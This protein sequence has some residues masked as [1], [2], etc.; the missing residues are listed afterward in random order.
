MASATSCTLRL[1]APFLF[2]LT[3]SVACKRVPGTQGANSG[4]LT[5]SWFGDTGETSIEWAPDGSLLSITT[6][7][8]SGVDYQL[9]KQEMACAVWPAEKLAAAFS[10][11]P[12]AVTAGWTGEALEALK[13]ALAGLPDSYLNALAE[14][15]RKNGFAIKA[16]D[17]NFPGGTTA[18]TQNEASQ[19]LI[20]ATTRTVQTLLQRE[21]GHALYPAFEAGPLSRAGSGFKVDL[22]TTAARNATNQHLSPRFLGLMPS[23]SATPQANARP[24]L[25][26]RTLF[27]RTYWSEAFH[28]HYCGETSDRSLKEQFP[29]T[30]AFLIKHTELPAWELRSGGSEVD[31]NKRSFEAIPVGTLR[32]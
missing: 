7:L 20:A 22:E 8:G 17:A 27:N 24:I 9:G 18:F 29:D 31:S 32:F 21:V 3:T 1:L 28:S 10:K 5:G 6:I 11:L 16:A 19:I 14:L 26:Q 23:P 2:A 15:H 4:T 30:H 25:D 13:Q 12:A